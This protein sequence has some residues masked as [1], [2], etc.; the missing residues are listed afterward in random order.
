MRNAL[1]SQLP[2]GWIMGGGSRR[3]GRARAE[4]DSAGSCL[5][6][7][8]SQLEVLRHE[9]GDPGSRKHAVRELGI[10]QEAVL[11]ARIL[12]QQASQPA[13]KVKINENTS[14]SPPRAGS[15]ALVG[16]ERGESSA[17]RIRVTE[18]GWGSKVLRPGFHLGLNTPRVGGTAFYIGSRY[19]AR[20]RGRGSNTRRSDVVLSYMAIPQVLPCPA[21]AIESIRRSSSFVGVLA[22]Q[23][24]AG[25]MRGRRQEGRIAEQET[26]FSSERPEPPGEEGDHTS[27]YR[28]GKYRLMEFTSLSYLRHSATRVLIQESKAS[29]DETQRGFGGPVVSH[30]V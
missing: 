17:M 29:G 11:Q 25:L 12:S 8:G 16:S 22:C 7:D 23:G 4:P 5:E 26:G 19:N 15:N 6:T 28:T 1:V 2:C 30:I 9:R 3:L 14:K 27:I 10:Q 21:N 13:E 20:S 18:Q 24:L